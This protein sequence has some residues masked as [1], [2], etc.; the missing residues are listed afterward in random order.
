[1]ILVPILGNDPRTPALSRPCSTTE[2]NRHWWRIAD[3]NCW[4][5]LAKHMCSQLAPIPH[6]VWCPRRDSN[7]HPERPVP[8]TGVSTNS[9]TRA[10]SKTHWLSMRF[11]IRIFHLTRETLS[12][13][14]PVRSMFWVRCWD[15]VSHTLWLGQLFCQL[16]LSKTLLH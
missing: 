2:L 3:S 4:L 5:M 10:H 12:S 9:T 8:K 6:V 1:M 13:A 14:P 7:S 15:L 16:R 11:T